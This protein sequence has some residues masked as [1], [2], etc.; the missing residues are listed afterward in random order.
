MEE[1]EGRGRW[2]KHH[3][4][5][6]CLFVCG[7]VY[8]LYLISYMSAQSRI[9]IH[10]HNLFYTSLLINLHTYLYIY[11]IHIIS[12][13]LFY[14]I[15]FY[16]I[17]MSIYSYRDQLESALETVWREFLRGAPSTAKDSHGNPTSGNM[18]T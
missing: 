17:S 6:A 7:D 18:L 8:I 13:I 4:M 1:G 14:Y 3:I 5:L 9:Y 15:I 16:H 11:L 12:H 2:L 10:T